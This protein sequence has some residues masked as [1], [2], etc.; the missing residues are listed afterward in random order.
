MRDYFTPLPIPGWYANVSVLLQVS[1]GI[2][3][4]LY[5]VPTPLA[6]S[7]QSG[8]LVLLTLAIWL[9]HEIKLLKYIPK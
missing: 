7:H 9:T 5:Y 4:L 3:T 8:S 1:L 6:A 2:A